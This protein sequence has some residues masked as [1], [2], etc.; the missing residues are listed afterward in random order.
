ML[1]K[2][3]ENGSIELLKWLVRKGANGHV[4]NE[5]GETPFFKAMTVEEDLCAWELIQNKLAVKETPSDKRISSLQFA[6]YHN[7][8]RVLA[9]LIEHGADVDDDAGYLGWTPLIVVTQFDKTSI[10]RFILTQHASPGKVTKTGACALRN[11]ASKGAQNTIDMFFEAEQDLDPA[12]ANEDGVTPLYAAADSGHVDTFIY[13]HQKQPDVTRLKENGWLPVHVAALEGQLEIL[14]QLNPD[15][16]RSKTKFEQTP[17]LLASIKG[18]SKVV[19]FCAEFNDVNNKSLDLNAETHMS[20][21][22]RLSCTPLAAAVSGGYEEIV[23][24]LLEKGANEAI[25]STDANGWTLL[26]HA[27]RSGKYDLFVKL[28]GLGLEPMTIDRFGHTPSSYSSR[29]WTFRDCSIIALQMEGHARL[30]HRCST[31]V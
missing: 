31:R 15:E 22:C 28:I 21:Q 2:A 12:P 3:A 7:S 24:F 6:A 17:L 13:L 26:H 27:A 1:H 11:A 5:K 16:L 29:R 20:E 23:D 14:Q 18:H 30:Y 19:K 4:F 8:E 10:V 9:W 25:N